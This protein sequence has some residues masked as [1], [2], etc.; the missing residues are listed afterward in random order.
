MISWPLLRQLQRV[1]RDRVYIAIIIASLVSRLVALR[2]ITGS[3][4]LKTVISRLVL[5]G[6]VAQGLLLVLSGVVS[7]RLWLVSIVSWLITLRTLIIIGSLS[8]GRINRSS[9]G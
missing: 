6:V 8:A 7:L 3:L 4:R 2:L 1:F 5:L 9:G